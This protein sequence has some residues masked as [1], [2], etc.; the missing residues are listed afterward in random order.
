MSVSCLRKVVKIT[1]ECW[2]SIIVVITPILL[3][4]FLT[5]GANSQESRCAYVVIL[6]AIFWT[7]EPIPLPVTALLPVVLFPLLGLATTEQ[8]CG[9]Y[10]QSTNMLFFASLAIAI[11]MECSSLH[12]RIALRILMIVG[13]DIR[14]LFAGFMITTMFLGIWIINTA[15]TAMILPIADVITEELLSEDQEKDDSNSEPLEDSNNHDSIVKYDKD[16]SLCVINPGNSR[17]MRNEKNDKLRRLLY[18]SIAYSATIGGTT[19]L[20]SNGPNLVFRFVLDDIYKGL[21]PVDY[22]NWLLFCIPA[23]I[24]TVCILWVIFKS[25]YMRDDAI[26]HITKA[27][28]HIITEKYNELGP[29]TFHEMAVCFLFILLILLWM[30][31]D[32]QFVTGWATL[33]GGDIKPKDATVAVLVVVLMFCIP[34]RPM[35]PYPSPSLLDWPTVQSKLSWGVIILRGG[36]FSMAE[37]ATRSGLTKYIGTQLTHLNFLSMIGIVIVMSLIATFST[38]FASNSAIATIFLPIA[39]QLATNLNVNP[40]LLMIPITLSC[41]YAFVLPVG[42]PANALV[43]SHANLNSTDMLIPGM[44]TK[45]LCLVIMLANLYAIGISIFDL[46]EFPMW[47]NQTNQT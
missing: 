9:P 11:S 17:E 2:K 18:I 5:F 41:S 13:T 44:I 21:P 36:G 24:I 1:K 32:P 20:T 7:F 8:A 16:I 31:R 14:K 27:P 23:T 15:A 33:I 43:F 46:N 37:T 6:M 26:S 4:P 47:A 40:L 28:K 22:T 29:I 42:T 45:L 30:F 25:I 34:S 35:G 38:E 3:L 10:L 19:T 12:K 39:G